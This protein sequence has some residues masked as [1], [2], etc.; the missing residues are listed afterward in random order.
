MAAAA[1]QRRRGVSAVN[2]GD[3]WASWLGQR[4]EMRELGR[5]ARRI[6][7]P[8]A[9]AI[10]E[11]VEVEVEVGVRGGRSGYASSHAGSPSGVVIVRLLSLRVGV[12]VVLLLLLPLTIK[13]SPRRSFIRAGRW[14]REDG[15]KNKRGRWGRS[16]L[17]AVDL[18]ARPRWCARG[19]GARGRICAHDQTV[20]S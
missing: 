11:Q 19:T 12:E 16:L 7:C 8:R 20:S 6:S 14:G 2:E 15:L 17:P 1:L 3:V 5:A 10:A 9:K 18:Q 13:W 4:D